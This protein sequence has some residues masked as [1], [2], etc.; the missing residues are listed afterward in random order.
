M[1]KLIGNYALKAAVWALG[2]PDD[3]KSALDAITAGKGA[4]S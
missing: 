4:K 3:V 2:H 1:W